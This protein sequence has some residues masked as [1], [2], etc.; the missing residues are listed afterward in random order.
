MAQVRQILGVG[1]DAVYAL[2]RQPDF[3]AIRVGRR[4]VVAK[5]ALRRWLENGGAH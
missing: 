3:P 5:E 2:A 4:Y 1:K